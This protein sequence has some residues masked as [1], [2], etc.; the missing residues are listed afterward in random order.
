MTNTRENVLDQLKEAEDQ[1]SDRIADNMSTFGVS[2]TIGRLL[3]IIYLNR[4][5]MTLDE[6]A[7]KTGMSKTRMSQVMRQMMALNIADKKFVKGSRKE[8]YTV[9]DNYVQTFISLFTTNWKDVVSKNSLLAKRLQDKIAHIEQQN[10]GT[11]DK[12]VEKKISELKQELDDWVAYYDWIDRL[13]DFF[14][15]GKVFDVVPV[16]QENTTSDD[17]GD[18]KHK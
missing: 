15:S 16:T 1:I 11:S 7:V 18:A 3:G 14:E 13:V 5:P 17:Q 2:S 8:H 6:L 4:E 9:E 10:D 12:Q